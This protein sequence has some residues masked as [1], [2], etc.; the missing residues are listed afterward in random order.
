MELQLPGIS[1]RQGNR[2]M[3]ATAL[4]PISLVKLVNQPD[5]WN[6]MG[7]QPH[8][9]RPVDKP[10]RRGIA[11]YLEAEEN[12]VLN[13]VVLYAKPM[14]ARFESLGDSGPVQHGTL[15]LNYGAQF[16]VGDGQH[17]I[18]AYSDVMKEHP[19]EEDPVRRRLRQ[20]GQ[21]VV[22][23]IDDNPL[24]RAQ[25]F[26]DLQRNTKP[27][28]ASLAMSMDRRQ[29]INRLL[30]KLIQNS[31]IPIFGE[32][33]SRVE[34]LSDSPGKFSAKLFSFKTIRYMT[35]T[36]V[37]GTSQRTTAGWDKAVEKLLDENATDRD[38]IEESILAL[39]IG[40]GSLP[41]I[42]EVIAGDRTAGNLREKTYLSS[43]GV[44][45]AIAYSVYLANE[46]GMTTQ[47]YFDKLKSVS[48]ARAEPS[49][50]QPL[51]QADTI[52]AG[53][54]V[55]PETGKVGSGRPAW[56]AAAAALAHA[57]HN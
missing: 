46:A 26:T 6:P 56:E 45:Y 44:L 41:D 16:D 37:I 57:V 14:E 38:A 51:S 33:G 7:D 19:D 22:I 15:F 11:D 3:I 21:P 29:A 24:H 12:F 35:G 39:W 48:F 28:T 30:I 40:L 31:N 18:G 47:A 2:Q 52:F 27:Q 1:Y 8:G 43:A 5:V 32:G 55:D 17:R 42:A 49:I 20:S 13:A 53:N 36:A 34:F 54:L 50:D 23:V 4:D 9:N 10:H 25:D